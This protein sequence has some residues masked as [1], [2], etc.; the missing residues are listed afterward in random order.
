[1]NRDDGDAQRLTV[2][3]VLGVAQIGRGVP[4]LLAGAQN[5][6]RPIR[7]VHTGEFPAMASVLKGGELLLT[8]GMGIG[9]GET[10]QRQYVRA[11]ADRGVAGL[12]IELGSALRRVPAAMVLEA[13]RC[14]LPLIA[15]HR[16]VPFVEVTE[17]IHR[18][19]VDQRL[20][21]L[22]DAEDV[23]RRLT[24]LILSGRDVAELVGALA[25]LVGNPVLLVRGAEGGQELVYH[26]SHGSPDPIVLA[27]WD[28]VRRGLPDAVASCS[29]RLRTGED[30]WW[31]DVVVLALDG[32]LRDPDRLAVERA[33][34]IIAVQLLRD[35]QAQALAARERGN[36]LDAL[37]D[38]GVELD[39]NALGQR[40]RQLGFTG[41]ARLLLPM[42][43]GPMTPGRPEAR[44]VD[45][46]SWTLVRRD[47]VQELTNAG[48]GC[49]SG[50]RVEQG[51]LLLVAG[52]GDPARRTE[53][54][55]LV[56]R[57]LMRSATGHLGG[58][59]ASVLS[60]GAVHRS[61]TGLRDGLRE[62]VDATP[63]ARRARASGFFDAARPDLDRLLLTLRDEPHLRRFATRI[64]DPLVQHDQERGSD[65]IKTLAAFCAAG[66][67]KVEAAGE[68]HLQRQSLYKRLDRIE[69]LLDVDLDDGD[70]R[71]SLHF[72]LRASRVLRPLTV[73]G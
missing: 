14:G 13:E 44:A 43:A 28:G 48:M 22:N 16:Q 24:D 35:V 29:A 41:D 39:D 47:L 42:V 12:V 38:P 8:T 70:V 73:E 46:A 64:L 66:G 10:R 33:A 69:S 25:E 26:V 5:L 63:I 37:L 6:G 18:E 32:P 3:R 9:S 61:W 49:L 40:A 34:N 58:P 59:D 72:A 23:T 7:W 2:A 4:E 67:R 52:L 53:V 71:L 65:L 36:F 50:L 56:W 54:A 60:V 20:A 68:L 1:M 57:A 45:A 31:G 21:L 55:E 30:T 51:D 19:L 27:A 62:T 15:L 11:L 17:A